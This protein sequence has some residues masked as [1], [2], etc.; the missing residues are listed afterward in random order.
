MH[1]IENIYFSRS[2]QALNIFVAL[3]LDG[4]NEMVKRNLLFIREVNYSS[5]HATSHLSSMQNTNCTT[6]HLYLMYLATVHFATLHE[7]CILSYMHL[8]QVSCYKSDFTNF[9][10]GLGSSF[11]QISFIIMGLNHN[12][13][14]Y[15][16][17]KYHV[18]LCAI[19]HCHSFNSHSLT[20]PN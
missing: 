13:S 11:R 17:Q 19:R 2:Q 7:K 18:F 12:L 5:L 1:K 15:Q 9:N 4:M 10:I 8:G 6:C 20:Q 14:P 3:L 16:T